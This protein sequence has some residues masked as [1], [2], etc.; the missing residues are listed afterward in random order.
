MR[1]PATS[2]KVDNSYGVLATNG[3]GD[4]RL[5]TFR[6]GIDPNYNKDVNNTVTYRY[7]VPYMERAYFDSQKVGATK[8]LNLVNG[9]WSDWKIDSSST[10]IATVS[11]TG[12]VTMKGSGTATINLTSKTIIGLTIK[13]MVSTSS[14]TATACKSKTGTFYSKYEDTYGDS[15][16]VLDGSYLRIHE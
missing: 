9:N 11:S 6:T 4:V 10:K 5:L 13:V 16:Q 8:Q 3:A 1:T 2:V 15:S 12:L 14:L 7:T